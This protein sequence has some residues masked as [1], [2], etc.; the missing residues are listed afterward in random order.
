[1]QIFAKGVK[2]AG[3]RVKVQ[4]MF[5]TVDVESCGNGVLRGLR[6]GCCAWNAKGRSA[7]NR[8]RDKAPAGQVTWIF[9]VH[10][11]LRADERPFR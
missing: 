8:S 11:L 10:M 3:A 5:L 9:W 6:V 2:K 4:V 7:N 1:M